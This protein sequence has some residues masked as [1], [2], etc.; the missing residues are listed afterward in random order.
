MQINH[1]I[2]AELIVINDCSYLQFKLLSSTNSHQIE[3]EKLDIKESL[4]AATDYSNDVIEALHVVPVDPVD[5][6]E[7]SV[8]TKG[9]DVVAD[10]AAREDKLVAQVSFSNI[11]NLGIFIINVFIEH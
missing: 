9:K 2:L 4:N 3:R 1:S 10:H 6:V 11:I 5:D 7:E 8:E